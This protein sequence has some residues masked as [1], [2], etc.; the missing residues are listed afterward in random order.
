[1]RIAGCEIRDWGKGIDYRR[2]VTQ[3][4]GVRRLDAALVCGWFAPLANKK[5]LTGGESG[6]KPPHSKELTLA[7][8]LQFTLSQQNN[9]ECALLIFESAISN[10][11]SAIE[12][13]A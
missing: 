8:Q 12:S 6:V 13:L 5:P 4:L 2:G 10:L 11:H 1:L 7:P 9:Q 3:L